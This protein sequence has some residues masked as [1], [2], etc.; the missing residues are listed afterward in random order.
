MSN[1]YEKYINGVMNFEKFKMFVHESKQGTLNPDKNI[2]QAILGLIGEWGEVADIIKKNIF[3]GHE[4]DRAHL[5]EELG[6]SA[7]YAMLLIDELKMDSGSVFYEKGDTLINNVSVVHSW[8]DPYKSYLNS[9][10]I[11]ELLANGSKSIGELSRI[12]N[13][14]MNYAAT[15]T[16]YY[17]IRTIFWCIEAVGKLHGIE[18]FDIFGKNIVKIS[19]R[20]PNGFSV[21][22]SINR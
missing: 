4:I 9:S 7:W 22:K 20:Y 3:Q 1:R 6:D 13:F 12:S 11:I 14:S 5:I 10:N 8:R 21:D 17:H 18:L 16:T 19:N 15:I 2:Q